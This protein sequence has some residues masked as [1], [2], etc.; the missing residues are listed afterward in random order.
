MYTHMRTFIHI[1][2]SMIQWSLETGMSKHGIPPKPPTTIS[3]CGTTRNE[4]ANFWRHEC[5]VMTLTGCWKIRSSSCRQ[6]DP[7]VASVDWAVGN[8]IPQ[9]SRF[10]VDASSIQSTNMSSFAFW[11]THCI[12]QK[13]NGLMLKIRNMCPSAQ[14][15]FAHGV[16]GCDRSINESWRRRSGCWWK[17]CQVWEMDCKCPAFH[18]RPDFLRFSCTKIGF[19][20]INYRTKW[21]LNPRVPFFQWILKELELQ[22]QAKQMMEATG[23]WE[24]RWI[25]SWKSIS[26]G[27][28]PKIVTTGAASGFTFA[29]HRS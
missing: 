27:S 25:F 20:R 19:W 28:T 26:S 4:G 16:H 10:W 15:R 9:V 3:F 1:C 6:L 11:D 5:H 14:Y 13:W 8:L 7:L 22:R 18:Q 17:V 29:G 24:I 21:R 2:T 12:P 23:T